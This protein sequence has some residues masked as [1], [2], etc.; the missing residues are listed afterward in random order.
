MDW[1]AVVS[2]G[3]YPTPTPTATERSYY[4]STYGL[5]AGGTFP[6]GGGVAPIV[7]TTII[8]SSTY[9]NMSMLA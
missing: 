3:A 8:Y 4:V 6:I 7:T 1:F 5:W 2:L 9:M